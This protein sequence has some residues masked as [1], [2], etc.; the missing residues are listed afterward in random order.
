M[1]SPNPSEGG[2]LDP[3]DR[4]DFQGFVFKV[5]YVYTFEQ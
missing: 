5:V 2:A 3:E 4:R 1:T